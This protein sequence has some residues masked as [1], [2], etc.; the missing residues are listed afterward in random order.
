MG[1]QVSRPSPPPNPSSTTATKSSSD[2]PSTNDGLQQPRKKKSH[3]SQKGKQEAGYSMDSE[4]LRDLIDLIEDRG[5]KE[6][7][8]DG[9]VVSTNKPRFRRQYCTSGGEVCCWMSRERRRRGGSCEE[10]HQRT[11]H[12]EVVHGCR[13]WLRWT[14]LEGWEGCPWWGPAG[15][16]EEQVEIEI[17]S[18]TERDQLRIEEREIIIIEKLVLVIVWM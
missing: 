6:G 18:V 1:G 2:S 11:S 10:V 13:I 12:D 14:P 4:S 8:R 16:Q 15:S 7:C 9:S 17:F 3:G 5:T